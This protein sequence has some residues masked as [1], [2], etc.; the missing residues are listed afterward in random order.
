MK[1]VDRTGVGRE[2]GRVGG[3][4]H[5]QRSNCCLHLP[6][7]PSPLSPPY[8]LVALRDLREASRRMTWRSLMD[9]KR[10]YLRYVALRKRFILEGGW[11]G[12]A[13][14]VTPAEGTAK[15]GKD[16]KDKDKGTADAAGALRVQLLREMVGCC[17]KRGR[18]KEGE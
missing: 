12:A 2:G 6:F 16:K 10:D 3:G 18:E 8:P 13:G 14:G 5:G 11:I 15:A 7:L 17:G 4:V 1:S 9:R